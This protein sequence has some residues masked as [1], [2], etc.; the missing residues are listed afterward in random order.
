MFLYNAT[1]CRNLARGA[2]MQRI[3]PGAVMA[4]KMAKKD[5]KKKK[6]GKKKKGKQS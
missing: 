4:K 3:F 1:F 2:G 5:V 6:Y